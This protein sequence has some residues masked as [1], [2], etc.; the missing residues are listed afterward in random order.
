M[1]RP[2][3]TP[4]FRRVLAEELAKL[5][6]LIERGMDLDRFLAVHEAGHLVA[7]A[8]TG[9]PLAAVML[10]DAGWAF[11][12]LDLSTLSGDIHGRLAVVVAGNVAAEMHD[13]RFTEDLRTDDD[14]LV[15]AL[16]SARDLTTVP[17]VEL[18]E[19]L[20]FR[21]VL[22]TYAEIP[23]DA[24]LALYREVEGQVRARLS[25]PAVWAVVER[26][27]AELIKRRELS[28]ED[29]AACLSPA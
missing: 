24:A 22:W 1:I 4:E 28:A 12:A 14:K 29:V 5:A 25:D 7:L 3:E 6:P 2:I 17:A 21:M 20:A 10:S 8:D 13:P 23:D 18:D 27:A 16:A 11:T 19:Y 9:R 15:A 26:I